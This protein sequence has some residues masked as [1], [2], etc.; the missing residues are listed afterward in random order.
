MS[1]VERALPGADAWTERRGRSRNV[2]RRGWIVRRALLAA[3]IGGLLLAFGLA[4]A[5]VGIGEG[6]DTRGEVLL[7]LASLPA[8]VVL[9]KLYGL[10][11]ADEAYADHTTVDDVVGVFHVGTAGVWLV[12]LGTAIVGFGVPRLEKLAVFWAATLV[13]VPVGRSI[14]RALCRRSATFVQNTVIVGAGDV[15]QLIARKI[16]QHPEYGLNVV[17]FVDPQPKARRGDLGDLTVGDG[18]EKLSD[19]VQRLDIERVV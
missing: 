9:A 14:G 4:T 7:L 16:L 6:F 15:G 1:V 2:W 10:Y 5:F 18:P 19:L 8:W 17:G 13:L 11:D 12:Y 3:D